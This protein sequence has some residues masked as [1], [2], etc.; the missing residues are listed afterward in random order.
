MRYQGLFENMNVNE[1]NLS[2]HVRRLP[3]YRDWL[4]ASRRKLAN[5]E[6]WLSAN[7]PEDHDYILHVNLLAAEEFWFQVVTWLERV[8]W[9][10]NTLGKFER[11]V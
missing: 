1:E 7:K 2:R 8:E 9:A 5:F 3:R 11:V 4:K 6:G 10:M